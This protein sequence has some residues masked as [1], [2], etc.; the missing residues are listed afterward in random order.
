MCNIAQTHSSICKHTLSAPVYSTKNKTRPRQLSP[1]PGGAR[2][3]QLTMTEGI[4]NAFR[5]ARL[6]YIRADENDE[7]FMAFVPQIEQDPLIHV[8]A[9]PVMLRPKTK[10]D[11]ESYAQSVS[12]SLLGV[13]ICL[14]PEEEKRR[15]EETGKPDTKVEPAGEKKEEKEGEKKPTIVGAITIGWGG[16]SSST[17]FNRTSS[18]GISL[19]KPYQ[20]KGYGREAINWM[21]DWAFTHA[22]L[23]TVSIAAASFNPRAMHL[24]E[25]IGFKLEGRR[26]EVIWFNRGWHDEVEFGI[27]EKE[28]EAL[29]GVKPME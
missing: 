28:W 7:H 2:W 3:K 9:S 8:L 10:K 1:Q 27:T 29:R 20:N 15:Q 18:I 4:P 6:E 24:Y 26:R 17:A 13:A 23:H 16:H 11:M 12:R 21:L 5:S 19:A 22:G 25:D 14:L